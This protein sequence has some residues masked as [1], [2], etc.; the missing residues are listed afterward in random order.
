MSL[1]SRGCLGGFLGG[2]RNG[3]DRVTMRRIVSALLLLA[4]SSSVAADFAAGVEAYGRGDYST[5]LR[6]FRP[7]AEQGDAAAQV[8]LGVMPCS[9]TTPGRW[10][11]C[12]AGARRPRQGALVRGFLDIHGVAYHR[13]PSN[14]KLAPERLAEL[15]R[16][17]TVAVHCW[18]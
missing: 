10:T 4:A 18:E 12:P 15:A 1:G 14:T 2:K 7:L 9:A 17:F 8:K 13:R 6:E 16:G 11:G 5:A 3:S